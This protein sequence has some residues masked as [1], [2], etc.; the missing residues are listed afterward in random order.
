MVFAQV[1]LVALHGSIPVARSGRCGH[2][3]CE[4]SSCTDQTLNVKGGVFAQQNLPAPGQKQNLVEGG[5]PR[6]P[7]RDT[8]NWY[9]STG[10]AHCP[11][12]LGGWL[13]RGALPTLLAKPPVIPWSAASANC[14]RRQ[15]PHG[16]RLCSLPKWGGGLINS[17]V[18]YGSWLSSAMTDT[19]CG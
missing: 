7:L 6:K 3:S 17:W 18:I 2:T 9:A 16:H 4:L 10:A 15:S 19:E 12:M 14:M 13:A 11:Q 1:F 5:L 8:T